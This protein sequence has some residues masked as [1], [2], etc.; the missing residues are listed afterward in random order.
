MKRSAEVE[1]V[2]FCFQRGKDKENAK[3]SRVV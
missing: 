2:F 3:L 1:N